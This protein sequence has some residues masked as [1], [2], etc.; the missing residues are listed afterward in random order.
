MVT[1][2]SFLNHSCVALVG[3]STLIIALVC[4]G[5]VLLLI[6]AFFGY[7]YFFSPSRR[8]GAGSRH[9]KRFSLR[10]T[11]S[12]LFQSHDSSSGG[13]SQEYLSNDVRNDERLIAYR[14]AQSEILLVDRIATGGFGVI[15]LA[16][17]RGREVAVKQLLPEK[18]KSIK[19]VKNFMDEIRLCAGLEHPKIV[20]FIGVAWSTLLDVAVII[21]Y[22]CGGDLSST[23]RT[24]CQPNPEEWAE[25]SQ[26]VKSKSLLALDIVEALVYLHSFSSPIIHR[27]LKAKN[28]LLNEAGDA[29]L[30][31]FG[32]SREVSLEET[33]TADVGTVAWI[34]PEV[35]QGERYT[36]KA[37]IYSFG[38]L[39]VEID[40]CR[41]PYAQ[42]INDSGADGGSTNNERP[43]NTRIAM[44]VSVGELVP[45]LS[46]ECPESVRSLALQCLSFKAADRPSAVEIHYALRTLAL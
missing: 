16:A 19:A 13:Y 46:N 25:S 5:S 38:V 32:I 14:I 4:V 3:N 21:E 10:S 40:T 44:R 34:A 30:S 43:T 39:L 37:D 36:E 8:G 29:K 12:H 45:S 20:E 24:Y 41:H 9:K 18:A 27:D 28:V 17:Y 42:Y 6:A 33:M 15:H 7:R 11:S 35:L 2:S 22:M 31:D 23:L 1:Y 26:H